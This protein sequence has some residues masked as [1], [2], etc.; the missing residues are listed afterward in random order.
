MAYE[1]REFNQKI[2][3]ELAVSFE[4]E[5][6]LLNERNPLLYESS[7]ENN[8]RLQLFALGYLAANNDFA[9]SGTELKTLSSIAIN[10]DK[11]YNL[12]A[13]LD[14][15]N[16]AKVA[17]YD[18]NEVKSKCTIVIRAL[19]LSSKNLCGIFSDT[20]KYSVLNK[21]GIDSALINIYDISLQ[22]LNELQSG[23]NE[24]DTNKL[25]SEIIN[26]KSELFLANNMILGYYANN[27][28][29]KE[30]IKFMD[31][32]GYNCGYLLQ[33]MAELEPFCKK[34]GPKINAGE[35][36]AFSLESGG[37]IALLLLAE[38]L[39][40][41]D[42]QS[43]SLSKTPDEYNSLLAKYFDSYDIRGS[44]IKEVDFIHSYLAHQGEYWPVPGIN[45]RW[46]SAFLYFIDELIIECKK[47]LE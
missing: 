31:I 27:G 4:N 33:A 9:I 39:S 3:R 47:C 22:A 20:E 17:Y 12:F 29:N 34:R 41:E 44:F 36:R 1:K 18:P 38:A 24:K 23:C 42:K 45:E 2:Y 25:L 21:L 19:M 11:I 14:D 35:D 15:V 43:L 28:D 10:I 30:L 16:N 46:R 6:K 8:L 32:T 5:R 40:P 37:N 13:I 7:I 26:Y